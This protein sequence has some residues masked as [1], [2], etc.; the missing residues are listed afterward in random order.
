M[1]AD[2]KDWRSS[3]CIAGRESRPLSG[4][5]GSTYVA[6]VSLH[7]RGRTRGLTLIELTVTVG[8]VAVLVAI[9]LPSWAEYRHRVRV[10]QA[11]KDIVVMSAAIGRY[12]MDART[13]PTSLGQAG[14]GAPRDPWGRPYRYL[15]LGIPANLGAAR[16][17]YSLVPINTDFDLYSLGPDGLS[18]PPL[19]APQSHDDIVRANNG[20]FVGL[21]V[22]Y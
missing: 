20:A 12:W 6:L 2:V 21:A 4:L 1:S 14:L 5:D 8:I 22:D 18:A 16:K 11:R 9:A 13:F 10:D 7:A 19:T 3:W 17:D 15:N